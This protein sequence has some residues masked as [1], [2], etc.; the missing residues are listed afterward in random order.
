MFNYFQMEQYEIVRKN[1][2]GL[3]TVDIHVRQPIVRK[4]LFLYEIRVL[5]QER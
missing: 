1:W 5:G 3:D 4:Q 2:C